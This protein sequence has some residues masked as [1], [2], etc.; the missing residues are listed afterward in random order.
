MNDDYIVNIIK[1]SVGDKSI[2]ENIKFNLKKGKVHFFTGMKDFQL[3]LIGGI[4]AKHI[5]LENIKI[6]EWPQLCALVKY[7]SGSLETDNNFDDLK[8]VLFI[9][10]DPDSFFFAS[11][12][13][14]EMVLRG[15]KRADEQ[16]ECLNLF[17]LDESFIERR[18]SC[19]SGGE[20]VKIALSIALYNENVKLYIFH[21]VI[22]WLDISGRRE[23][24]KH[25]I[26]KVNEIDE[27]RIPRC[28]ILFL[29]HEFDVEEF[30]EYYS[31]NCNNLAIKYINSK[32]KNQEVS[33]KSSQEYSS[34][35]A[36]D[37]ILK[38]NKVTFHNYKTLEVVRSSPI[39][40]S[41]EYEFKLG[42]LYAIVGDNGIG[43]S[44]LIKLAFGIIRP[45]R[46]EIIFNKKKL[47]EYKRKDLIEKICY[48]GQFPA[49]QMIL[50]T[51]EKYK[52][53]IQIE[54]LRD[55]V[56]DIQ[57]PTSQLS[58]AQMRLLL[59][60]SYV[61]SETLLIILDE[62][63]WGAD[64]EDLENLKSVIDIIKEQR[65]GGIT[66]I[67]V[68]HNEGFANYMGATILRLSNGNFEGASNVSS[69][70][71]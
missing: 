67:L 38:F 8:P 49:K 30:E 69:R 24:W 60:A 66:I 29:E 42:G 43:K 63:T 22:P 48:I 12:V 15:I 28:S 13:K 10:A 57:G 20:K 18:I 71:S 46:G 6:K 16:K 37:T 40:N 14:E 1:Y 33:I 47:N 61:T 45:D 9:T 32:I 19:L 56:N 23:L 26:R 7:Y 35:L 58:I 70:E 53:Q 5:P 55:F 52:L 54:K 62:P 50:G 31:E 59:I 44:T 34:P 64:N 17:N 68:T 25:C 41:L 2:L 4:I 11:K 36:N 51:A 21:G 39:I 27:N 3:Y 65:N